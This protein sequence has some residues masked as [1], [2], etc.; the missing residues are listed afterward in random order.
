MRRHRRGCRSLSWGPPWRRERCA[1]RGLVER[2]VAAAG[3]CFNQP[4]GSRTILWNSTRAPAQHIRSREPA[5]RSH[6]AVALPAGAV[7]VVAVARIVAIPVL[8]GP[9]VGRGGGHQKSRN[10]GEDADGFHVVLL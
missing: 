4:F 5:G 2:C 8:T 7:I 1:R 3:T 10:G 9:G 6:A